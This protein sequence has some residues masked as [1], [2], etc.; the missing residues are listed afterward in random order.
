MSQTHSLPKARSL[1]QAGRA[2]Q[3]LSIRGGVGAV[4]HLAAD[5]L[6]LLY[7]FYIWARGESN[8]SEYPWAGNWMYTLQRW[9]GAITFVYIVWHTWHLR[10]SGVHLLPT[11][12]RHSARYKASLRMPWAIRVLCG[13]NFCASWHFAYGLWLFAAKW[14]I[15]TVHARRR[16]GYVCV[17]IGV[18]SWPSAPRPCIRSWPIRNNRFSRQAPNGFI[19]DAMN[20]QSHEGSR[21]SA[22]CSIV[23]NKLMAANSKDYRCWRR[24]GRTVGG[25]QDRRNGR[26]TLTSSPSCR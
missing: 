22:L 21:I 20:I 8:V 1:Y 9:T 2:P 26:R 10:F 16:F 12:T 25:H 5:S 24:P 4:R 11:R 23:K 14:G 15:T 6:S 13:R 18:L 19:Y 3:Q 17:L 7:G